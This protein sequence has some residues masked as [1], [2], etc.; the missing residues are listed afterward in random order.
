MGRLTV[1]GRQSISTR[2]ALT[3]LYSAWKA[4]PCAVPAGIARSTMIRLSFDSKPGLVAH[5]AAFSCR[6]PLLRFRLSEP[7]QPP[8]E[9]LP[10]SRGRSESGRWKLCCADSWMLRTA[11]TLPSRREN[12]R[13]FSMRRVRRAFSL[14]SRCRYSRVF[15]SSSAASASSPSTSTRIE[16]S[17]VRSSWDTAATRSVL[18]RA[19]RSW[20]RN[21]LP[22][23]TAISTVAASADAA[24]AM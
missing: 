4:I 10:S 16:A 23:T 22:V 5:S 11:A 19:S 6:L 20:R 17:G 18:R 21:A 13:K 2:A 3:D 8:M 24:T 7:V 1:S 9:S 12:A 15:V 14:A